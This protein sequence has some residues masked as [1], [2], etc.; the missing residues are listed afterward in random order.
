MTAINY[1][2]I[3][4]DSTDKAP[5]TKVNEI[6]PL[7]NDRKLFNPIFNFESSF[8]SDLQ[9]VSAIDLASSEPFISLK[10]MKL[11]GGVLQDMNVS[12][13]HKPLDMSKI[14]SGERYSDRTQMSLKE[15]E[16]S[17]DL[18]SGYLYYTNVK[19]RIKIHKPDVLVNSSLMSFLF[20]S[21]PMLLEYGWNSPNTFLNQK[22]KLLFSVKTYDISYDETGQ[23]DL[24]V[25]GMAFN[26][27][28]S[29]VYIGDL[30]D[31]VS[32]STTSGNQFDGIFTTYKQI[33]T[34]ESYINEVQQRH[35]SNTNDPEIK[36]QYII[37]F[38]NIEK[39]VRG[40]ISKNFSE[41]SE[42]L[43]DRRL[44]KKIAFS[45]KRG[46]HKIDCIP[47]HDLFSTLCHDTLQ[48][49]GK[50]MPDVSKLRVIYGNFNEKTP[51]IQ[52][53]TSKS[54]AEFPINLNDFRAKIENYRDKGK[55]VITIS[56]LLNTI[57]S[58]FIENKE[59]WNAAH[60]IGDEFNMPDIAINFS[61]N[62]DTIDL[63]IIDTKFGIP[64]TISRVPK[65]KTSYDAFKSAVLNGLTVPVVTLG[66]ANSFIKNIS[67]SQISDAYMKAAL[68]ERMSRDRIIGPRSTIAPGQALDEVPVTPLTLP[69]K[70]AGNL[71]GHPGWKTFRVFF[72]EAGIFMIDGLYKITK[73]VHRLS[74]EGFNTNIE[75]MWH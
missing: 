4:K 13:F 41:R 14:N 45:S 75:F 10:T 53:V 15:I 40:K 9:S 54:I 5:D 37:D 49:L 61:N 27:K 32:N 26:D 16:I 21:A 69:L 63:S 51:K 33:K 42:H 71:L 48:A 18:A 65:G 43:S 1:F 36:K 66:H 7:L 31:E 44:I 20:P 3:A 35:D 59:Y 47:F 25:E 23:I 58:N 22:E 46:R 11:D 39:Q 8:V 24:S 30:G 34:Y 74:A 29:N 68:I 57:I 28:F 64:P 52:G 50:I 72:L 17:T 6:K 62:G 67:L 60:P 73:V 2:Y 55:I 56:D 19:I 38:N 70:G 12:F